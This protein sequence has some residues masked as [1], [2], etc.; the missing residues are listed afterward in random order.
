MAVL[1]GLGLLCPL[2][3][4]AFLHPNGQGHG[5]HQQL[6]LPPCSFEVIFGTR[7]PSCGSTTAFAYMVRG[8][9]RDAF[10]SNPGGALLAVLC[11][12][13][14]PWTLASAARGQ[15]IVWTPKGPHVALIALAIA[16]IM[17]ID[18]TIRLVG[19]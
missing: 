1:F 11:V 18:W 9:W 17:L 16:T 6:G 14:W 8:R 2:A 19:G 10:R 13:A 12:V 3:I 5:T 15:W 4:A 7:C